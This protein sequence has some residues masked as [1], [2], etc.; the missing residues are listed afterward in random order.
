VDWEV[1]E[2]ESKMLLPTAE[3]SYC[4][5]SGKQAGPFDATNLPASFDWRDHNAVTGTHLTLEE[6][7]T[8]NNENNSSS[9]FSPFFFR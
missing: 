2:F 9:P 1:S 7:K 3:L 4:Q 6:K 8:E 5:V